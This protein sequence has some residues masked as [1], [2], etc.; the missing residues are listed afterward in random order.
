M[1]GFLWKGS[2]LMKTRHSFSLIVLLI[3]A[4]IC[5]LLA[6]QLY[7]GKLF[8][9]FDGKTPLDSFVSV[10]QSYPV[11]GPPSLLVSFI[12]RVLAAYHSPA[13]GL[14]QAL[15]DGGVRYHI[16]PAYALA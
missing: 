11:D 2:L 10:R 13:A 1:G 15:S 6:L 4:I 14:G 9:S 12:N 8:S 5:L 3:A 16:D 7:G